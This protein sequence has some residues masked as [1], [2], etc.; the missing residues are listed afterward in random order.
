MVTDREHNLYKA[1]PVCAGS[2]A[3]SR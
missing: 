2:T 1:R 3:T